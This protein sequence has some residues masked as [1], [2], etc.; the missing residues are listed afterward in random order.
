MS[1]AQAKNQEFIVLWATTTEMS[2]EHAEISAI[3]VHE[4]PTLIKVWLLQIRELLVEIAI[5]KLP[6][7]SSVAG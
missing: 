1:A 7:D 4:I 2:A 6:R 5:N 3:S